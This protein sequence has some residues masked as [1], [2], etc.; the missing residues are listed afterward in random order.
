MIDLGLIGDGEQPPRGPSWP[1]SWSVSTITLRGLAVLR[2][3]GCS[4]PAGDVLAE[5]SCEP[6]IHRLARAQPAGRDER[7]RTARH[8]VTSMSPSP[9]PQLGWPPS[10]PERIRSNGSA[11]WSK[12][13][14]LGRGSAPGTERTRG[15]TSGC[16]GR[17]IGTA[18]Q[19]RDRTS[20]RSRRLHSGYR[21]STNPAY[22]QAAV[23]QHELIATAIR[24]RYADAAE[25]GRAC[26]GRDGATD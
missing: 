13:A 26:S 14:G 24:R 18:D 20:D 8:P 5:A 16:R 11:G 25:P 2:Q 1:P 19:G 12:E 4:K 21:C 15:S 17:S 10:E 22:H 6:A 9:G 7:S 3:Q 23:N